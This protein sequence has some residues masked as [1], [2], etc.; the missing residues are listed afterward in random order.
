MN[1]KKNSVLTD[2]KSQKLTQNGEGH[3]YVIEQVKRY[4][5]LIETLILRNND[6]KKKVKEVERNFSILCITL[7]ILCIILVIFL[8][9]KTP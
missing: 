3:T 6:L 7:I 8:I 9:K 5:H 1:Q 2:E 4:S